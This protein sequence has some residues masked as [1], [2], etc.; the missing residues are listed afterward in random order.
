[1]VKVKTSKGEIEIDIKK[2]FEADLKAMALK[3]LS[4][5]YSYYM[6]SESKEMKDKCLLLE[7]KLDEIEDDKNIWVYIMPNYDPL[8]LDN[9]GGNVNKLIDFL[10]EKDIYAHFL[11]WGFLEGMMKKDQIKELIKQPYI[12]SIVEWYDRNP[13]CGF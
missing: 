10:V 3:K 1:M 6:K 11:T 8:H 12:H 9:Y 5:V 4:D 13:D 7:D 2:L